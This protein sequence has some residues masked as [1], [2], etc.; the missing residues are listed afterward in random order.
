VKITE[1][2]PKTLGE[3]TQLHQEICAFAKE[4][5]P[6]D[7]KYR[8]HR[9]YPQVLLVCDRLPSSHAA[10]E[11]DGSI[12]L[13][14]VAQEQTVLVVKSSLREIECAHASR[15][16]ENNGYSQLPFPIR[17]TSLSPSA[18]SEASNVLASLAV[19]EAPLGALAPGNA[20]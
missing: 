1:R 14:K 8:M 2:G 10:E 4:Y 6:E 16:P 20:R 13:R 3:I 7:E 5:E 15:T 19:H 18:A 9:S 17:A 11:D 12:K